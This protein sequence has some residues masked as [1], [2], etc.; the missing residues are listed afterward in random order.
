MTSINPSSPTPVHVAEIGL[1]Q[2]PINGDGAHTGERYL[3]ISNVVEAA[4]RT[5]V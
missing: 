4:A 5:A 2:R 3:S 1:A